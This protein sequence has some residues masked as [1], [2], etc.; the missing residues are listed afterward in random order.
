MGL[1][2]S[3]LPKRSID[4]ETLYEKISHIRPGGFRA[5]PL[6]VLG[7]RVWDHPTPNGRFA[8]IWR[9]ARGRREHDGK[10]GRRQ[11]R[12]IQCHGR[13]SI[14]RRSERDRRIECRGWIESDGR[15]PFNRRRS[16]N[17]WNECC[18]RHEYTRRDDCKGRHKRSRWHHGSGRH[19]YT[20][21]DD[22]KGRHGRS[23]RHGSNGRNQWNRWND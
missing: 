14:D 2:L 1:C 13:C 17:R 15:G 22:C 4:K 8:G 6:R 19:E 20:R 7:C 12:R 10:Y 11:H 3:S 16:W 9:R 23:G 5:C 18:G 21:R